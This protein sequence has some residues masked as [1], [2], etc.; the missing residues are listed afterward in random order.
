MVFILAELTSLNV[1]IDRKL[2]AEA[3]ALFNAMGMTLSTAINVFVRQAV[4][5][6]AIPFQIQLNSDRA[7]IAQKAKEAMQ[8]M[9]NLSVE[10]GNSEM[11]MDEINAEIAEY[12]REKREAS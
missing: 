9:Q 6:Q 12:R 2:K 4:Q 8:S 1:K 5:E 11:T 7:I 3:D 10:N